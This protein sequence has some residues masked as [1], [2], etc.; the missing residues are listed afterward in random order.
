LL[1]ADEQA[2]L[3]QK[4]KVDAM[5]TVLVISPERRI[6]GRFTGYQSAAQ[7]AAYLAPFQRTGSPPKPVVHKPAFHERAWAAVQAARPRDTLEAAK[8][9]SAQ[10]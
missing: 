3:V 5:P 8:G 6:V 10:R 1:D 7:L 2:D 9:F 4:L